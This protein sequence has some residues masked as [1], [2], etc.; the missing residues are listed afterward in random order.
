[1]PSSTTDP[2][3]E[4]IAVPQRP[5]HAYA[6]VRGSGILPYFTKRAKSAQW[7]RVPLLAKL[8]GTLIP[9]TLGHNN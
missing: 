1:M 7:G 3:G 5:E 2:S 6:N 9:V 8:K 4:N